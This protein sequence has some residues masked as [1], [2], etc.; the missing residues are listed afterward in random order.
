MMSTKGYVSD[1]EDDDEEEEDDSVIGIDDEEE[2]ER[3]KKKLG[4]KKSMFKSKAENSVKKDIGNA[5]AKRLLR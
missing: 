4:K 1:N 5:R 2:E 3:P